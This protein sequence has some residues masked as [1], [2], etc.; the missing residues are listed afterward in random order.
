M[1][2]SGGSSSMLRRFHSLPCSDVEDG[3]RWSGWG[4]RNAAVGAAVSRRAAWTSF[5]V[6]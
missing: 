1:P 2:Y 5:M 4:V 3:W 6:A